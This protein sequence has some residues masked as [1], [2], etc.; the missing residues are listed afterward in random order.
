MDPMTMIAV[1]SGLIKI[2]DELAGSPEKR[3]EWLRRLEAARDFVEDLRPLLSEIAEAVAGQ[4]RRQR[5]ERAREQ[6]PAF[7]IVG[8]M[9]LVL[10]LTLGTIG[11]CDRGLTRL[12]PAP[13]LRAGY[14]YEWPEDASRDPRDYATVEIDGRMITT[15]PVSD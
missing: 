12:E 9:A 15:T 6:N 1:I 3:A 11:C 14:A 8:S 5:A 7:R 10:L 2:W 4:E 13:G